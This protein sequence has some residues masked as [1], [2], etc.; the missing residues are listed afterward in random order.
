M[1]Q[2]LRV[3]TSL[4]QPGG[5]GLLASNW[6]A[7]MTRLW[8]VDVSRVRSRSAE[9]SM[10]ILY[11]PL[12]LPTREVVIEGA[13]ARGLAPCAPQPGN[14]NRV[15]GPFQKFLVLLDGHDH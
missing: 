6:I 14:I 5:R 13:I 8:T 3:P 1:R 11:T 9:R 2:S 15:F 7:V 12:V 4:R 10:R